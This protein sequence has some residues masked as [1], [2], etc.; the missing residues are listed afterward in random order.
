MPDAPLIHQEIGA[1]KDLEKLIAARAKREFEIELTFEKRVEKQELAYQE[2]STSLHA[3]FRSQ[4]ERLKAEYH[5]N[6]QPLGDHMSGG[7]ERSLAKLTAM[8]DALES[9]LAL[10]AP[11]TAPNLAASSTTSGA[12]TR[13]TPGASARSAEAKSDEEAPKTASDAETPEAVTVGVSTPTMTQEV[14]P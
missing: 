11:M 2:A 10:Q 8:I 13:T 4:I 9:Y 3:R 1:F 5:S 14:L 7:F 6:A 12:S